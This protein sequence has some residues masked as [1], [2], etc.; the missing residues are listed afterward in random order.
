M[1]EV[2]VD[3]KKEEYNNSNESCLCEVKLEAEKSVQ[4]PTLVLETSVSLSGLFCYPLC[5][6]KN[7]EVKC[8]NPPV[9]L[10]TEESKKIEKDVTKLLDELNNYEK[11]D[12]NKDEKNNK[13]II[14]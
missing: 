13:F 5:S 11:K 14:C 8:D 9:E 12:E 3:N 2:E 1:S 7:V 4:S 10:K 6:S